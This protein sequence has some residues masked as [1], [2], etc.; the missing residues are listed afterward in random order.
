MINYT[1]KIKNLTNVAIIRI[2]VK[3][4]ELAT[5][6]VRTFQGRFFVLRISNNCGLSETACKSF[7]DVIDCKRKTENLTHAKHGIAAKR[8]PSLRHSGFKHYCRFFVL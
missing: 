8:T 4:P 2:A 3:N 7:R 1:R 6:G 5:L